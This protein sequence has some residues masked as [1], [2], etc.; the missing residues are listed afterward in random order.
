MCLTVGFLIQK[1]QLDYTLMHVIENDEASEHCAGAGV[2][3][4][5]IRF[6]PTVTWRQ[7]ALCKQ[8]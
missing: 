3:K 2:C 8:E 7:L 4:V 1:I 5:A 6:P